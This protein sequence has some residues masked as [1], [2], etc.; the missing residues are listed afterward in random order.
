MKTKLAYKK[1][2]GIEQEIRSLKKLFLSRKKVVSLRGMLKGISITEDEI[3]D[4][5]RSLFRA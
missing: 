5:K 2:S 1:I 3:E 4:A